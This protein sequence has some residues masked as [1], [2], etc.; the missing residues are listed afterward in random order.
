MN[1]LGWTEE[2]ESA[3]LELLEAEGEQ[4]IEDLRLGWEC[5]EWEACHDDA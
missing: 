1:P 3:W 4:L 5:V 2:E